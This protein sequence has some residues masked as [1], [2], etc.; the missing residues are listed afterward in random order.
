LRRPACRA[1]AAGTVERFGA[2][3]G[4]IADDRSVRCIDDGSRGCVIDVRNGVWRQA[5]RMTMRI[6]L[7]IVSNV[8]I[9]RPDAR[10][11]DELGLVRDL[12]STGT[13]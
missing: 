7:G 8:D 4:R 6:R 11:V 2:R 10:I 1:V 13:R 3:G 5:S 9:S 12:A